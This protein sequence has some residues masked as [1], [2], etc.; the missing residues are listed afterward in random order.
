M[1]SVIMVWVLDALLRL[2]LRCFD[3]RRLDVYRQMALCLSRY[4]LLCGS[5]LYS[6][7]HLSSIVRLNNDK[8]T[9]LLSLF[10]RWFPHT[11]LIHPSTY[12]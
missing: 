11:V 6:A 10:H 9:A 4:S 1:G 2:R 12:R 5:C 7:L 8:L 3:D